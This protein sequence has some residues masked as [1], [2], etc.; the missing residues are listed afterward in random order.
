MIIPTV[1]LLKHVHVHIA[2]GKDVT[3]LIRTST[4]RTGMQWGRRQVTVLNPHA[5]LSSRL[6]CARVLQGYLHL[7]MQALECRDGRA[8]PLSTE[9]GIMCMVVGS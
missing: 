3:F 4:N 9:N 8:R 7:Q 2:R 5:T 6:N 1:H